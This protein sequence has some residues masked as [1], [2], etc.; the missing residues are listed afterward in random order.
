MACGMI[1][2]IPQLCRTMSEVRQGVDSLDAMLV[3]LL[4]ERFAYMRAAAR[5]KTERGAVRDED[6]KAQVIANA[7]EQARAV[8]VPEDAVAA[9]WEGLVEASIAYEQ[10]TWDRLRSKD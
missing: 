5:I 4:A 9:M 10:N 6:R 2:P 7:V 8:A 3:D 1:R